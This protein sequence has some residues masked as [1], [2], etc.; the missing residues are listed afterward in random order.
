MPVKAKPPKG[1]GFIGSDWFPRL[2]ESE[3]IQSIIFT[4]RGSPQICEKFLT[5]PA[6]STRYI[7]PCHNEAKIKSGWITSKSDSAWFGF[8]GSNTENR[9][10][11]AW[12]GAEGASGADEEAGRT[13]RQAWTRRKAPERRPRRRRPEIPAW[14]RRR[15]RPAAERK[16][17][18]TSLPGGRA[19]ERPAPS[20]A[21]GAT[22]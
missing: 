9:P 10:P 3:N 22:T 7:I 17:T 13:G 14:M 2:G 18:T 4:F 15:H 5:L 16:R 21:A 6:A 19:A 20:T 8:E 1:G 12:P 11:C